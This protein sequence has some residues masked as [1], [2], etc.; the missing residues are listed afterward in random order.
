MSLMSMFPGGGG[1]NNQPLKAPTNLKIEP[2]GETSF[3]ISWTDPENEYSQPS[4]VLIGEWMFTRV[5]RKVGSAPVNAN[6]G[7]L[8]VESGQKNQY[9]TTPYVDTGLIQGTTYY[10]GVFAFTTSR[11]SSPGAIAFREVT[12]YKAV[13]DENAWDVI[14]SACTEG[15]ASEIW[16]PGDIKYE[17]I[18]GI[19]MAF[20]IL[21]FNPTSFTIADGGGTPAILF[22]TA[23][24]PETLS[25]VSR[26][27]SSDGFYYDDSPA[28]ARLAQYEAGA[29]STLMQHVKSVGISYTGW[30][31]EYPDQKAYTLKFF[32]FNW[33][34]VNSAFS[35][36]A[37]RIRKLGSLSG[38][39]VTWA[40]GDVV[41]SNAG[42]SKM[43]FGYVDTD[44]SSNYL[45]PGWVFDGTHG[46]NF[47]FCFGKVGA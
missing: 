4:G 16:T 19:N 10:Y 45:N 42:P 27:N 29:P 39:A 6:D 15:V 7:V 5:V 47:G 40:F 13:L 3:Y 41:R 36:N 18:S 43:N 46:V 30:D 12:A 38:S 9:Q 14:N 25:F 21:Q 33:S 31:G 34:T 35:T 17:T 37:Q 8:I 2:N 32:S 20:S 44:G 23:Y 1:T 28:R 22:G 11:V 24:C 26:L